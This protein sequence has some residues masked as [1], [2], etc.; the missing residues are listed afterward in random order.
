MAP[1]TDITGSAPTVLNRQECLELLG[2]SRFGRLAVSIPGKPPVIRPVHYVFD[3]PSQSV[4]IR[5][6]RGSKLGALLRHQQAAFEIDGIDE[7]GTTGW[8]VI[9][10]G[11]TEEIT[12]RAEIERL[13][14][15]GL[16]SWAPG[17]SHTLVRIRAFTV[18]GRRVTRASSP[19]RVKPVT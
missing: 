19:S 5:S 4:V 18:T 6:I 15:S 12:G 16:E 7:T 14:A 8:S 11:G 17:D 1:G 10:T 2:V 13:L 9:I 3:Q